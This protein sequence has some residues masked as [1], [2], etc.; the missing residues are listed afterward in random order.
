VVGYLK[1]LVLTV[2]MLSSP[3]IIT[4]TYRRLID[5][6]QGFNKL[7]AVARCADGML[8]TN[9]TYFRFL[10]ANRKIGGPCSDCLTAHA[11]CHGDEVV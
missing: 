6:L 7:P 8:P 9:G 3:A 2:L 10:D 1:A 11:G 4:P 5:V